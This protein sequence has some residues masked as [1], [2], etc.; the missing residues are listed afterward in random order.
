MK[1]KLRPVIVV[2]YMT[3]GVYRTHLFGIILVFLHAAHHPRSVHQSHQISF[4]SGFVP[5]FVRCVRELIKL[6]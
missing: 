1:F 5:Y 6:D 4:D 3:I 2:S